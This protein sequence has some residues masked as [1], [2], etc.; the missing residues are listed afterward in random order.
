[1]SSLLNGTLHYRYIVT[2]LKIII[3]GTIARFCLQTSEMHVKL[4]IINFCIKISK[5]VLENDFLHMFYID[6]NDF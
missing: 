3:Y 6:F 4:N 5:I 1:L 2:A